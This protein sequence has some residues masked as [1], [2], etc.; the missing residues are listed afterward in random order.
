[1]VGVA[2]IILI[3]KE[4]YKKYLLYGLLLGGLADTIIVLVLSRWLGVFKY[5]NLGVFAISD[6]FSIWTPIAW[7]FTVAIY[8]YLMPVKKVFVVPLYNCVYSNECSNRYGFNN[9]RTV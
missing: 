1:M 4:K 2:S 3:P 6:L 5:Q 7:T 9:F 8:F